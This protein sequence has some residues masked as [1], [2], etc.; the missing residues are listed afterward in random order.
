MSPKKIHLPHPVAKVS[1]GT[2]HAACITI[3]GVLYTWGS[4]DSGRLGHGDTTP[5]A[6]PTAVKLDGCAFEISCGE[7]HSAIVVD[8]T[9]EGAGGG[10]V[11]PEG[12]EARLDKG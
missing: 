11:C 12:E 5:R 7:R 10:Y 9:G 8:S 6:H 2:M 3:P 1:C 4:G